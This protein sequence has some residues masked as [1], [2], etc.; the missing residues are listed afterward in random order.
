MV[1]EL[2][3]MTLKPART[4]GFDAFDFGTPF[5]QNSD[6]RFYENVS[7]TSPDEVKYHP[8]LVGPYVHV[9][10]EVSG[11][12]KYGACDQMAGYVTFDFLQAL[13][14]G[15]AELNGAITSKNKITSVELFLDE[16]SLGF[17]TLGDERYDVSNAPGPIRSFRSTVNLDNTAKGEHTLRVVGTDV[18]GNRRQFFAKTIMFNGPGHNCTT[19]KRGLRP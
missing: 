5:Y 19:R 3:P 16:N 1:D 4:L 7:Y 2:N 13:P 15:G 17:A 8:I 9:V 18:L 6:D 12:Q 11:T 10:G 14:C